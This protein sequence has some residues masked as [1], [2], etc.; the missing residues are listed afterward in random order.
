MSELR[1]Y[2]PEE[3]EFVDFETLDEWARR[4]KAKDREIERLQGLVLAAEIPCD[5][6]AEPAHFADDDGWTFCSAECMAAMER[7]HGLEDAQ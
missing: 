5:E 7:R 1:A 2:D 4:D 6:C 3:G